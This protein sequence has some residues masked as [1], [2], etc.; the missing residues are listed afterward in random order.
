MT[1]SPIVILSIISLVLLLIG[2]HV[3]TA[4]KH[5]WYTENKLRTLKLSALAAL[6]V[7]SSTAM[8]AN[9]IFEINKL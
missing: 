2:G 8:A 7:L 3:Y 1:F 5:C 6:T 9:F 4:I